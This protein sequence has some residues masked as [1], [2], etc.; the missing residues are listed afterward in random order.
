MIAETGSTLGCALKTM[1]KPWVSTVEV[2]KAQS[3]VSMIQ[4][5]FEQRLPIHFMY[6]ER[7]VKMT[8]ISMRQL[9]VKASL[10]TGI[11]QSLYK[12]VNI[13]KHGTIIDLLYDLTD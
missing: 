6:V 3:Y 1:Y 5:I 4:T 2:A 12:I 9:F 8:N 13:I 7:V 11:L 10:P